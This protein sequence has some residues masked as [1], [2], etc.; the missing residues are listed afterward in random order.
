M[1]L[2]EIEEDWQNRIKF[3]IDNYNYVN[4]GLI[5]E[6]VFIRKEKDPIVYKEIKFGSQSE[7]RIAQELERAGVLF[8]PLP[9]AVRHETGKFHLDHRE[10]DFLVCSDGIWGILEV[11]FHPE[12][13]ENDKEKDAWFKQS[14]ILCIEH[15]PS[16]KCYNYPRAVIEEFLSILAK[17]KR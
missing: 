10:V 13:Y 9:L 7:V 8:F 5:T 2:I 16:E 1:Q 6:T 14:G 3:I 17:Y 15:Y 12:R 11:S 4:Q